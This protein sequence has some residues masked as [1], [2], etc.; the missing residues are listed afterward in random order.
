M[1]LVA[2]DRVLWMSSL[3]QLWRFQDAL[4]PGALHNGYDRLYVPQVG[5]ITGDLDI[6]DIAIVPDGRPVFV[7]TLFSCLA[8]VSDAASFVP[9]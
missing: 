9:L 7:N 4:E 2:A 8:T 1:G 5:Y 3:Y 6:H